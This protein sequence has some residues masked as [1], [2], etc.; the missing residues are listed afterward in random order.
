MLIK[1]PCSSLISFL[2][3]NST[4]MAVSSVGSMAGLDIRQLHAGNAAHGGSLWY[5]VCV[6]VCGVCGVCCVCVCLCL[7]VL[8]VCV[9]VCVWCVLC[10]C[11]VCLCGCVCVCAYPY[12]INSPSLFDVYVA[13]HL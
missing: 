3:V 9:C 8:C 5:L 1:A 13:V 6:C 4:C 2:V 7:C 10:V 12:A 11:V